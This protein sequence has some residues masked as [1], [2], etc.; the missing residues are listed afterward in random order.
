MTLQQCY[1]MEHTVPGALSL[2]HA[3]TQ[4]K[5]VGGFSIGVSALN[6]FEAM[7]A[8]PVKYWKPPASIG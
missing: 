1:S 6:A 8:R 3:K 5:W 7:L 2:R 4:Q